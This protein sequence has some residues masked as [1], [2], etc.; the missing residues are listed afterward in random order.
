MSQIALCIHVGSLAGAQRGVPL[1]IDALQAQ[2][3]GAT[4]LLSLGPDQSGRALRQAVRM[5]RHGG[6]QT[7]LRGTLL[8]AT[9][10][11]KKA[12]A[13]LARIEAEGF[14]AGIS[15]WNRVAWEQQVEG[16]DNTAIATDLARAMTAFTA[17]FGHPPRI[18]G[19]PD[20]Q[21]HR[22]QLRLLQRHG[23][24][25]GCDCR[26]RHPFLPVWQGEPFLCPQLPTTLPPLTELLDAG[27]SSEAAVERLLELTQH[28]DTPQVFS[29][30]AE[31]EGLA[32]SA[33]LTQLWQGWQA[34][35][36]QLVALS[37]LLAGLDPRQLP[38]AEIRRG[39]MPLRP[40]SLCLQGPDPLA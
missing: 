35:G 25:L 24:R 40:R 38:Y 11:G 27:A 30:R 36:H 6:W 17:L 28:L 14:E 3:A 2:H 16:A 22:H 19:A 29:L 1:L 18:F 31:V 8:P 15:A 12:A 10:I 5:A 33:A 39:D 7:A 26:G 23:F 20:W 9:E 4:F 37:H 34:Q 21:A 13:T 32:H